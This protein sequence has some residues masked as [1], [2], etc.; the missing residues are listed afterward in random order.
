LAAAHTATAKPTGYFAT[1]W[2]PAEHDRVP[3]PPAINLASLYGALLAPLLPVAVH[4]GE[5]I[6][7]IAERVEAARK[8]EREIAVLERKLRNE[9]QINRKLELRRTMKTKQAT[10]AGLTS[11]TH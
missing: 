10:L 11:T 4:A 6:A 5:D 1:P 3:L 7:A 2:L 9:P 8:L